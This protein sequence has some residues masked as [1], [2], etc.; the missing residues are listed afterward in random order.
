VKHGFINRNFPDRTAVILESGAH[1]TY[2]ELIE[3]IGRVA[4]LLKP[5]SQLLIVGD[6]DYP[7]LLFYLA[8]LECGAVPLML[9]RGK[10]PAHAL[11]LASIFSPQ[12]IMADGDFPGAGDHLVPAAVEGDYTLFENRASSQ[13][14]LHE[15][16]GFL[17]ATSGSTGSPKLVRLSQANLAANATAI[18]EYL[19]ITPD[20][21]AMASLP[22][23]Y[24]YGLSIVNSHLNA[25]ASF[26]LSSLTMMDSAYWGLMREHE[27]TSFAGVPY[28]YEMLLRLRLERLKLP[29]LRKMTQA[30][31]RLARE[32]MVKI[33]EACE[34]AGIRFCTMYGQTEASPRIS[35]LPS[36]D[37]LRKPNCIG[38]PIPGGHM[39]IADESGND[40]TATG[41]AG[42]LVYE[43]ANVCMGYAW[44]AEEL[45]V[46]D[47]NEGV[48]RTG[49]IA[50]CDDEGYFYIE[51][52]QQR[53]LKIYGNRISLDQIERFL[54]EKGLEGAAFGSDEC[55]AV[56]I[57]GSPGTD[58]EPLRQEIADYA[59]INFNAVFVSVAEELP[60]L[61]TGKVDYRCLSQNDQHPS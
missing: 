14:E 59:G 11:K 13:P 39:W 9:A 35:Y 57:V 29:S 49:D 61:P 33:Y 45:Q 26:V 54:D 12:Q 27:V 44:S 32:N 46:G 18:V 24:S 41:L 58:T 43:G 56:R 38:I 19:E 6:N 3:D 20:D 47:E 15:R 42:E 23:S 55:L 36:E 51:G 34:A 48:L 52:R 10:N 7:T 25:G 28:H 31:G 60:R 40:I 16:L 50:R 5:R 1:K 17:S 4:R 22:L 8:A 37:T 30:G 2:A 21:R 53:F